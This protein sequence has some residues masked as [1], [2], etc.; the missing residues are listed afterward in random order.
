MCSCAN[1]NYRNIRVVFLLY[2]TTVDQCPARLSLLGHFHSVNRHDPLVCQL[3]TSHKPVTDQTVLCV[4]AVHG[5]S[6]PRLH[7]SS[8]RGIKLPDRLY[9]P[10]DGAFGAPRF[11]IELGGNR[12]AE[13][14]SACPA[15]AHLVTSQP[16]SAASSHLVPSSVHRHFTGK[17]SGKTLHPCKHQTSTAQR[18]TTHACSLTLCACVCVRAFK[19]VTLCIFLIY[20]KMVK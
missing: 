10:H 1:C 9:E 6:C 13:R 2:V 15:A 18:A 20:V 4:C 8:F 17:N 11:S 19:L 5:R 7:Q 16:S 14:R 3:R 12:L